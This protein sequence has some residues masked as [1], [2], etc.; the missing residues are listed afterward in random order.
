MKKVCLMVLFLGCSLKITFVSAQ[1]TTTDKDKIFAVFDGRTPCQEIAKQLNEQTIPECIK[2][3]WRLIFYT[4]SSDTNSGTYKLEGFVFRRNNVLKGNW[5]L[6]KGTRA[7][8]EAL[9]YQLNHPVRGTLYFQKGDD[10]V[11]F[12][13]DK[14]KNIMVGNRN[15]S[16]ALYRTTERTN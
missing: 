16:Y 4:N 1:S 2:I 9:V 12:F 10:D 8:P 15:F 14:E 13:L 11:I 5:K 3:K 7:D 6:I